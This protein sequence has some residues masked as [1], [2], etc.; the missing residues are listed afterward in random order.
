ME[1]L[2]SEYDDNGCR[3]SRSPSPA[4]SSQDSEEEEY[5]DE[6]MLAAAEIC[7]H[8]EA[9]LEAIA[10]MKEQLMAQVGFLERLGR[11]SPDDAH[12]DE[13]PPVGINHIRAWE[14]AR[15]RYDALQ[16]SRTLPATF[17]GVR[18]GNVFAP[19]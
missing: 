19:M 4:S 7:Q 9:K 1:D 11:Y 2:D 10:E 5:G 15:K 12:L 14:A 16:R 6:T 13:L 3:G 18:A 8:G 17:G